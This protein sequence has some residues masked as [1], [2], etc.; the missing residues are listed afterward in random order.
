VAVRSRVIPWTRRPLRPAPLLNKHQALR[1]GAPLIAWD[2]ADGLVDHLGRV[3]S[4]V[5]T[6]TQREAD[7]G[8]ETSASGSGNRLDAANFSPPTAACT[9]IMGV[10][11]QASAFLFQTHASSN[12]AGLRATINASGQLEFT[13]GQG[14]G[15]G[16]SNRRTYVVTPTLTAG[17]LY[18]FVISFRSTT[19]GYISIDG[20]QAAFTVT[21]TATDY[22]AGTGAGM[23]HAIYTSGAYAYGTGAG[24]LAH[25]VVLPRYVEP[26]LGQSLGR[27]PWQI[28]GRRESVTYN[29]SGV[30][31]ITGITP[32][33]TSVS[34]AWSGLADEFRIDGGAATALPDGTS[35]DTITG[36]TANQPYSAPG[37]QLR[38]EGGAWSDAVPFG[39][40]NPATGGGE[41]VVPI[42]LLAAEETDAAASLQLAQV[43]QAAE[44]SAA[45]FNLLMAQVLTPALEA[46]EAVQLLQP[47]ALEAAQETDEA[48]P[49]VLISLGAITAAEEQDQAVAL[50]LISPIA[51]G[52]AVEASA[53]LQLGP[54]VAAVSPTLFSPSRRVTMRS[55]ARAFGRY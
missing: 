31:E 6:V 51:L 46:D 30:P 11:A 18:T 54:Q 53:A 34:V 50:Q 41:P 4:V 10:R 14:G 33:E 8:P 19:S 52:V 24:A 13:F 32:S 26:E 22:A 35:P 9:V 28:R 29:Y 44:E 12:F 47:G 40:T 21:G 16:P 15:T 27:N 36:L 23:L 37:L 5:G 38:F 2:A 3:F 42:P 17:Q 25:L 45:A 49:L 39:T 43:I 20:A 55:P 1:D 48:V 7:G